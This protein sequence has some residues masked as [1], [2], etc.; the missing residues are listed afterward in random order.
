MRQDLLLQPSVTTSL[1]IP[2]RN[3]DG[4]RKNGKASRSRPSGPTLGLSSFSFQEEYSQEKNAEEKTLEDAEVARDLNL[5][6]VAFSIDADDED[7]CPVRPTLY[8]GSSSS[9]SRRHAPREGLASRR[10]PSSLGPTPE[11]TTAN[12]HEVDH[13]V[14]QEHAVPEAPLHDITN[15]S[16]GGA[17]DSQGQSS[18]RI[19]QDEHKDRKNAYQAP[20]LAGMQ[21]APVE[22]QLETQFSAGSQ[23]WQG[24]TYQTY[25]PAASGTSGLASTAITSTSA[26]PASFAPYHNLPIINIAS[27]SYIDDLRD[28]GANPH[29]QLA[30]PGISVL[31]VV[32]EIGELKDIPRRRSEKAALG[33]G[34]ERNLKL[35]TIKIC[36]PSAGG[37]PK[38]TMI[39]VS[40]WGDMADRISSG[41]YRLVKGDVVWF[42]STL[43]GS[44]SLQYISS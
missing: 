10:R 14:E 18:R 5:P 22:T 44:L 26:E 9:A 11:V 27:L 19:V 33:K 6:P 13:S 20:D 39:D 40:V 36:Q 12:I 38:M 28:G 23:S 21:P 1:K 34:Y 43:R 32:F 4:S 30:S 24:G 2:Q 17:V 37:W 41:D 3:S 35:C 7:S 42:K 15:F 8:S 25:R 16:Y 31:A 29:A